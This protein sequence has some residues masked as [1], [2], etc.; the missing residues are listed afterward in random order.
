MK[1]LYRAPRT[2]FDSVCN[3]Y[4][5]YPIEQKLLDIGFAT[6]YGHDIYEDIQYILK[7]YSYVSE[8]DIQHALWQYMAYISNVEK[9]NYLKFD[10][11]NHLK[12][13]VKLLV[14]DLM[15]RFRL[16]NG[17]RSKA[18]LARDINDIIFE[19][20]DAMNGWKNAING[21]CDY[22]HMYSFGKWIMYPGD[23]EIIRKFNLSDEASQ[24][25]C[26]VSYVYPEPWYGS[27]T[28]AKVIVLGNEARYDY[29]TSCVQNILLSRDHAFA[30][31]IMS[32]VNN[33][34]Q[35]MEYDFYVPRDLNNFE[36][37]IA[38]MDGYNSPT[39]RYWLTEYCYLANL[40]DI[41]TNGSFYSKI[42]VINANPYPS[43]GA[44]PL[45]AGMLPSHYF[46]RQLVRYIINNNPE[47]LFIIP[48]EQLCSV[49][50]TILGDVY[51]AMM[52][53]KRVFVLKRIRSKHTFRNLTKEQKDV[54][55][56]KLT[57]NLK[58]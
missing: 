39:Y 56:R 8:F 14:E 45:A 49:W 22:R 33:W 15:R 16:P 21:H 50:Q 41:E 27:P 12:V 9:S 3:E 24:D 53:L 17:D 2:Y 51:T 23:G 42:A 38:R 52:M 46:L 29:F 47:V 28:R 57:G 20:L 48:S 6:W 18:Y 19:E 31:D 7:N 34:M 5:T 1:G 13:D 40:L 26:Y 30:E 43:I 54:L 55:K 37:Q 10:R 11:K 36:I 32:F 35:L 4:Q 58:I 44:D 25:R